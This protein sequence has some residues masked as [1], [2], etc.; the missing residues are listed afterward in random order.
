MNCKPGDL[1]VIVT[2]DTTDEAAL[3][4]KI[5]RVTKLSLLSDSGANPCWEYDGPRLHCYGRE[6]HG[7]ADLAL[8]PIRDPGEDAKDETIQWKEVPTKQKEPA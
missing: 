3:L 1:A 6:I 5:I 7:V 2:A 4:G 8:R